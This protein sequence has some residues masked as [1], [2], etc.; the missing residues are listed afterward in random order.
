MRNQGVGS[1]TGSEADV[2]SMIRVLLADDQA[3]V[4]RGLRMRLALEPGLDVVG[5]AADGASAVTLARSLAPDV[6]LMDIEM[7][8]LDGISATEQVKQV[9]PS[10]C[11]VVLTIHDDAKTRELAQKAGATAF[12]SKHQIDSSLMDAIRAAGA[13]NET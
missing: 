10:C 6:V 7:P 11:V 9:L 3:N 5:E 2:A 8:G 13:T 12:V 4:R 1:T